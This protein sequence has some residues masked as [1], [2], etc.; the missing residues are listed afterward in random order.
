LI[1]H[2]CIAV[3]TDLEYPSR[4]AFNLGGKCLRAFY[5]DH[6]TDVY[7]HCKGDIELTTLSINESFI[8]YQNPYEA[9]KVLCMQKD[10]D[11][12]KDILHTSIEELLQR[13]EKL[14]TVINRSEDLNDASKQFLWKAKTQNSCCGTGYI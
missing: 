11:D 9:D 6:P 2:L 14:E 12:V 10:L 5:D 8:S 1:S 3:V 13:G 4:V 7:S